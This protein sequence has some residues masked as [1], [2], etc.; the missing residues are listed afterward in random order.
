MWGR[1]LFLLATGGLLGQ[2]N[3][4]DIGEHTSLGD[5][6]ASEKSVQF[7]VV[8][9]GQLKVARIDPLLL[10]VAGCVASQ[11]EDLSGEVL[12]DGSQV[13][14]SAGTDTLGVVPRAEKTV[15]SPDGELQP[16][17][18]G[19]TLGLGAGLAS[20][21][22]SRH[23]GLAEFFEVKSLMKIRNLNEVSRSALSFELSRPLNRQFQDGF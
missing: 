1:S 7:L 11:L 4:L 9:D 10:V 20:L 3:G 13:N 15:N 16:R 5:G 17:T 2:K 14:W 6:D 21:S 19:A 12:H 18:S 8:A 23:N 22:T